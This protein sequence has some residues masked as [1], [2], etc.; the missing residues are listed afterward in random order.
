[1]TFPEWTK[2]GVYGALVGAVAVSI[3]GFGWGGWTTAGGAEEMADNFA[4][5]QVTLAMVPVCLG[6]SEADAERVEILATLREASSFQQRK[7]MMDTG[8]ATLP[9]ADAPSR[10]L[11][12]ACLAELALDGS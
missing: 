7:A 1:M 11:A 12:D 9:G 10:D 2:S 8:W 5:E 4:A 6:L 3:L